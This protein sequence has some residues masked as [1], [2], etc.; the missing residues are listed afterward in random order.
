MLS[1]GRK[2]GRARGNR[3]EK[4]GFDFRSRCRPGRSQR[5]ISLEAKLCH[6]MPFSRWN[7]VHI[8]DGPLD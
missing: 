3:P 8:D 7:G 6:G 5:I 2:S 4:P 1:S